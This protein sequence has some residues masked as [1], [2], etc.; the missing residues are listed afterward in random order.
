[1]A[2]DEIAHAIEELRLRARLHEQS[3]RDPLTTLHN[4]RYLVETVE[5]EL[6][7]AHARIAAVFVDSGLG[8]F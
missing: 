4:R 1:M 5:R 2:A 8:S 7:R 6:Y 3:I